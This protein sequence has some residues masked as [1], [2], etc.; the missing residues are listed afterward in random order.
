MRSILYYSFLSI[1]ILFS[2][3]EESPA[4]SENDVDAARNFI[5]SALDGNYDKAESYMVQDSLNLQFLETFERNY[6]D[7]MSPDDKRSYREASINIHA[8]KELNDSVSIV[9]YSNSFKKQN[10]SLKVVK[11]N[12]QWL[13][14]FKYSFQPRDTTL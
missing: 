1:F 11:Q 10:D 4:T 3:S 8:V 13:V 14:D 7:R 9:N 12:D 5:R 2:C 6:K